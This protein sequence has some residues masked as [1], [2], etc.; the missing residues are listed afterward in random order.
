MNIRARLFALSAAAAI[1][2]SSPAHAAAQAP[3]DQRLDALLSQAKVALGL[4]NASS[5]RTL[6][7]HDK[8][9]YT[10]I[11]GTSVEWDDLHTGNS[12]VYVDAGPQSGGSGFD[13]T[14]A[15]NEAPSGIV[16]VDDAPDALIRARQSAYVTSY[17]LWKP[18][19][20]GAVVAL[21]TSRV[22]AGR[23]YDV[24][25]VTL[26][27]T[28]PFD[29]WLDASS[30]LPAR[31][32]STVGRSTSQTQWSDY[33]AV[34]GLQVPYRY[35]LAAPGGEVD[36]TVTAAVPNAADSV[37]HLALP[38]SHATD[39]SIAN[40]TSTSIPFDLIDNHVYLD[41]TI[42][43]KGPFRLIFDTGGANFLD[44]DIAKQLGLTSEGH[45]NTGGVG[46]QTEAARFANVARLV[47][48]DAVL[49]NQIFNVAPVHRGFGV[50][51]GKPV[52][53]L[54]G[55]EVLSRYITTF[56]YQ[57]KRIIL[58]MPSAAAEPASSDPAQVSP[59]TFDDT[60]PAIPCTID[61]IPGTCTID[62]G[63]R[64]SFDL[65]SPFVAAH[66]SVVS[67]T[68]TQVGVGGYG[69]G[70]PLLNRLGRTTLAFG[71]FTLPDT[72][73]GYTAQN[74]GAFADP[75]IAGNIGAGV[76]KRF[77]VTFDYPRKTMTLVPNDTYSVADTYERSGMFLITRDG[78][79]VVEGVRPGT[80]A[81]DAGIVKGDTIATV[82]GASAS[83][84][85]LEAVRRAFTAPPSTAVQVG[86]TSATGTTKTV[87]L[88]LRDYV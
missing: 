36:G 41:A 65:H 1:L 63:S 80:P 3:S 38:A 44:V 11:P 85:G 81:A 77:T 25:K 57:H 18:D 60:I 26:P 70:G 5:I 19:H 78:T 86:V 62:T 30:H 47:I 82:D 52:D 71:P 87:T 15:W 83:S 53:G 49:T 4:Q 40:G 13:G 64:D 59:F 17:G 69:F 7:M 50:S 28:P 35:H 54:I 84:L 88:T 23:H 20:G 46:T 61:A 43:G 73:T 72:I 66:P 51:G 14:H 68:A 37:A 42:D 29:L 39:F 48:G 34:A 8:V 31:M 24:V 10:G 27:G 21:E 58:R 2:A 6:T 67:G 74:A 32:V 16:W 12:A 56:D 22:D 75:F 33:R 76:L 9:V 45:V 79:L 55:F